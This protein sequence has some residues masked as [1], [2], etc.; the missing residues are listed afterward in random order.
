MTPVD[1]S[2]ANAYNRHRTPLHVAA[3]TNQPAAVKVLLEYGASIEARDQY[4]YSGFTPLHSAAHAGHTEVT[5]TLL[6]HKAAV[7]AENW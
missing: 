3:E 2:L 7:D 1:R 6:D 4:E 5:R